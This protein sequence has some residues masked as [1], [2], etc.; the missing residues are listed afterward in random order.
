M[1]PPKYNQMQPKMILFIFLFYL[2]LGFGMAQ[3]IRMKYTKYNQ[4]NLLLQPKTK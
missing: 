4:H 2:R 3:V 1:I